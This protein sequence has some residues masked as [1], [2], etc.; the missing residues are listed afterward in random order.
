MIVYSESNNMIT[1]RQIPKLSLIKTE[2][3]FEN[4]VLTLN[5]P[6]MPTL[7][8]KPY[9]E[10]Q[11][12]EEEEFEVVIWDETVKSIDCGKE[13]SNWLT[14]FLGTKSKLV[15]KKKNFTRKLNDS[16]TEKIGLQ[17]VDKT[18]FMLVSQSSFNEL[19]KLMSYDMKI[20]A[21]R[22]NIIVDC[23]DGY[24]EDTWKRILIN[25][26]EFCITEL[27][28]R[29]TIPNVNQSDS[30]INHEPV[31]TLRRFRTVII[32]NKKKQIFGISLFSKNEKGSVK[33][34]D[35]IEIIE[36]QKNKPNF[37]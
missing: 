26:K 33:V 4:G 37:D 8:L 31:L 9:H 10:L 30:I 35:E 18:P 11:S 7:T 36:F 27:C 15:I 1:Q 32:K 6:N 24:Y 13:C 20:T 2:I 19:K 16:Q 14:E 25:D 17:F 29:C 34:G 28:T 21:F 3:N 12:I 22:P 23:D 5:A